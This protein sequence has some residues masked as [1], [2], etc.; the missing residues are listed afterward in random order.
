M[1]TEVVPDSQQAELRPERPQ[2]ST[3]ATVGAMLRQVW[4]KITRLPRWAHMAALTCLLVLAFVSVYLMFSGEPAKLRILYQNNFR[5]AQLSVIVDS[6]V[7]YRGTISGSGKKKFGIFDKSSSGSFSKV[8][9]VPAGKHVVQVHITASAEAYDQAKV[10]YAEFSEDSENILVIN[11]ARHN[12]LAL[13]LEGGAIAHVP[14]FENES[15]PSKSAFSILLSVLGTML[16]ASISF[17]VQEFWKTH[18]QRM[19]SR[20]N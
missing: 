12:A 11:S 6:T 18:K 3:V 5:S 15:K 4:T 7:I 13:S 20:S 14:G 10:A 17:L 8:V 2:I 19:M 16:S 9:H 1:P